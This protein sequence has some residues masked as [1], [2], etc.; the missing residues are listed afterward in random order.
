MRGIA[1]PVF[2]LISFSLTYPIF[3]KLDIVRFKN[4][5]GRLVY[6]QVVWAILYFIGVEAVFSVLRLDNPLHISDLLWQIV[7]GSDN[8]LN[9]PMWF[10]FDLIVISILCFLIFYFFNTNA[11]A[12]FFVLGAVAL[13]W[14]YAGWNAQLCGSLNYQLSTTIG[15]LAEMLPFAAL[16]TM[17]GRTKILEFLQER[18]FL[19]LLLAL[20]IDIT[21]CLGATTRSGEAGYGGTLILVHTVC[22]FVIIYLL[23]LEHHSAGILSFVRFL[24]RYS[25]G[26]YCI[27]FGLGYCVNQIFY[28]KGIPTGSIWEC[29]LIY[30][31][32]ILISM[33]IGSIPNRFAKMLVM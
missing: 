2:M 25:L 30:A 3:E 18:R 10:Q 22:V 32:C 12:I 28:M 24:A 23:P 21:S 31:A 11:F 27:H 9:P 14:Q 17:A 4:R 29:L 15:R 33:I 5:L 16:G 26:V 6:P 7:F 8:Y 20:I 1:V 13:L 19:S